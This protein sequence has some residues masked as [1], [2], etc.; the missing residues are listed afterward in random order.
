[1]SVS[2]L[3]CILLDIKKELEVFVANFKEQSQLRKTIG[4]A[5]D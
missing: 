2:C 4:Y 3:F 1:M 5:P